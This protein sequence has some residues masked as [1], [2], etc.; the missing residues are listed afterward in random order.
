[1]VKHIEE[2]EKI[3]DFIHKVLVDLLFKF[4][5]EYQEHFEMENN[6]HDISFSDIYLFMNEFASYIA[7]EIERDPKKVFL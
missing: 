2:L 5:P 4:L 6:E 3:N 7:D 1:M